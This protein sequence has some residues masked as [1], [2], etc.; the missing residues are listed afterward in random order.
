MRSSLRRSSTGA[1]SIRAFTLIELLVV[2]TIIGILAGLL[3]PLGN[4]V[5]ENG[6]RV[7]AKA[8]MT[9]IV[10]AVKNYQSEYG[11][12]PIVAQTGTDDITFDKDDAGGGGKGGQNVILMDVLRAQNNA[13]GSTTYDKTTDGLNA[14]RIVYFEYKDAKNA[15]A[16]IDGFV[17]VG[18][19]PKDAAGATTLK[20]GDLMDNWGNL[21]YVRIDANYSDRVIDPYGTTPTATDDTNADEKAVLHTSVIAWS[22]GAKHIQY[23][24]TDTTRGDFSA[25]GNVATWR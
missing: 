9:Q 8:T 5:I 18:A 2:I 10:S 13:S 22:L 14:R 12:F 7:S 15:A 17:P 23:D 16:P 19:K 25:S 4:R 21:Y 1:L 6:K 3:L 11:T 24:S 20:P